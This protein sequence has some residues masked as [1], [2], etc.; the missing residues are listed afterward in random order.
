MMRINSLDAGNTSVIR[1]R[2]MPN[3]PQGLKAFRDGAAQKRRYR[4]ARRPKAA[5]A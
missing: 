4:Q 2:E 5:I 3:T 1:L